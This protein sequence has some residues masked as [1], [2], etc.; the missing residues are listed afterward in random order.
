MNFRK[1]G[2]IGHAPGAPKGSSHDKPQTGNVTAKEH[3]AHQSG[4]NK[5][6]KDLG[7][8]HHGPGELGARGHGG[9]GN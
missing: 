9:A 5:Q 3:P 1:T 6:T 8:F 4:D 2:P 7:G